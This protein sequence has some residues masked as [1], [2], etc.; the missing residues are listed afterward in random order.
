MARPQ[1]AH[2][3][4]ADEGTIGALCKAAGLT[5]RQL[6][7]VPVFDNGKPAFLV[8]GHAGS[9]LQPGVTAG[10]KGFLTAVSH[11]MRIC[12][13]RHEI[14]ELGERARGQTRPPRR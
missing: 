7:F 4:S 2:R 3:P 8:V 12:R 11:A 10:I 5:P 6:F 14:H 9:D 13:L 1:I